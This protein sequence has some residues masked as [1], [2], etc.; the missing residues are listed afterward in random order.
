MTRSIGVVCLLSLA[1][2]AGCRRGNTVR[3]YWD[4]VDIT[5]TEANYKQCQDRF[6]VFAKQA[7]S[8]PVNDAL[9]AMDTLLT[10]LQQDEV[11]YYVY[12]EW[13]D[14]AFYSLLSP[15]RNA[16]L[17]SKAVDRMALDGI[18]STSS[19]EPYLKK[20]E[21]IQYNQEGLRAT[22]P[23]VSF[24]DSHSK[25]LILVLDMSCPSCREALTKMAFLPEWD[26]TR[27]IA[28]CCNYGP[29]P[30]IPGWEFISN[31]ATSTVFDPAMTPV[32]FVVNADGIVEKPYT[33]AL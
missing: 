25:T 12:S 17:Y 31:N 16:E 18:L 26:G 22:V 30:D 5:V 6:A 14:G 2:I 29:V 32:Y 15:C 11:S 23:G 4:G 3:N 28:V 8:A 24:S 13:I 33:L 20:R 9:V 27:H 7:V 10:R 19:L 21:W 1:L